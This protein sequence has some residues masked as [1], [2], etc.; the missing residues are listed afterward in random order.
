MVTIG[1]FRGIGEGEGEKEE[2]RKREGE[3][4]DTCFNLSPQEAEADRSLSLRLACST[5][6]V[7]AKVT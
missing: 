1:R 4:K 3:I 7:T 5:Q 6:R 2:K